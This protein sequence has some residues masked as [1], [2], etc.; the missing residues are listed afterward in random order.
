MRE[1]GQ[2]VVEFALILPLLLLL[3][4]GMFQIGLALTLS[5]RLTH[6]AQQAA[7]A[8][9]AETAVPARCDTALAVVPVVYGSDPDEARCTEPGGVLEVQLTDAAPRIGPWP[10]WNLHVIGRAVTP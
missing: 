7:V 8:G 4:L 2:A 6:A 10:V 1:P 3:I 5:S 9:A